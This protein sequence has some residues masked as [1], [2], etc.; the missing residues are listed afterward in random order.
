MEERIERKEK[1]NEKKRV[2][3]LFKRCLTVICGN[4]WAR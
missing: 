1:F 3:A 4:D 2:L